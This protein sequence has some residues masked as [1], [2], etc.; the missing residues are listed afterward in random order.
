MFENG[1][2]RVTFADILTLLLTFFVFV[3][4]VSTFKTE[5]FQNFWKIKD[6]SDKGK[7]SSTRAGEFKLI[8]NVRFI[9]LT[10]VAENMVMEME[11]FF[12]GNSSNGVEAMY[13]ENR[14]SLMVSED[15]GF[16]TGKSV[17]GK[18]IENV[19]DKIVAPLIKNSYMVGIEGH[20]DSTK[21]KGTGNMELSLK[22][23]EAVAKILITKGISR[24][25]I[26]ISGYGSAKPIADNLSPEGRARN[27]RVEINIYFN[28]I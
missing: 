3:V 5:K 14:V 24:E 9:K 28:S 17:A 7:M 6:Q 8:D 21:M 13:N 11:E 27:R 10:P 25:R 18:E 22:R 2:W 20:T 16:E 19:V 23:A 1:G 4:A 26:R 15:I 12:T